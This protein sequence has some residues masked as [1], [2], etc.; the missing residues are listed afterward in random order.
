[1]AVGA[2][3]AVIY[4]GRM[5]VIGPQTFRGSCKHW[6]AWSDPV[7]VP[8]RCAHVIDRVWGTGPKI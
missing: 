5:G 3:I 4:M 1:V 7:L 6:L 2:T 8:S